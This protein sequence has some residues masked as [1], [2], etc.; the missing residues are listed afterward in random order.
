M[1]PLAALDDVLSELATVLYQSC[2]VSNWS[3]LLLYSKYTPDGSISAHDYDY[4]LD[5][6]TVDRGSA[7]DAATEQ[8]ID[9]LTRRHWRLTQDLGQARWFKMTVTVH[10]DGRFSADFEYRDDYKDEDIV[11]RG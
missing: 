1:H 2:P 11:R 3:R 7:P 6:G 5:D 4:H 8:R 9:Q 10:R